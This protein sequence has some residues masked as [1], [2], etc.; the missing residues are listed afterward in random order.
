MTVGVF[1]WPRTIQRKAKERNP[2]KTTPIIPGSALSIRSAPSADLAKR[3]TA[4]GTTSYK[5]FFFFFVFL[6]AA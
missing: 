4:G 3:P 2:K 1:S 5:A 6:V